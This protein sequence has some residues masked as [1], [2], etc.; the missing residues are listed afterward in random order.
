VLI[1]EPELFSLPLAW[2]IFGQHEGDIQLEN[3]KEKTSKGFKHLSVKLEMSLYDAHH[4]GGITSSTDGSTVVAV[5]HE[6]EAPEI[7]VEDRLMHPRVHSGS[8]ALSLDKLGLKQICYEQGDDD[9]KDDDQEESRE[10]PSYTRSRGVAFLERQPKTKMVTKTH[11][12]SER[13]RS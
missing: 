8:L 1:K 13:E 10:K 9:V 6:A 2:G 7:Y 4:P 3:L 5:R 12:G 11:V